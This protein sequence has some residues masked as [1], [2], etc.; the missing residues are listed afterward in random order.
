MTSHL[1]K[2]HNNDAA[3][4][5]DAGSSAGEYMATYH[6]MDVLYE[7]LDWL[8]DKGRVLTYTTKDMLRM[9]DGLDSARY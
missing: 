5:L 1:D 8:F 3:G 7:E 4:S 2:T 6:S 9:V